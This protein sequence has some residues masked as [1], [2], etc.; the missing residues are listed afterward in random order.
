MLGCLCRTAVAR[1]GC[2]RG[3]YSLASCLPALTP[4]PVGM[5]RV[6][7]LHN[8]KRSGAR[9]RAAAQA[10]SAPHPAMLLDLD[11]RWPDLT[12]SWLDLAGASSPWLGTERRGQGEG[13]EVRFDARSSSGPRIRR[14][15]PGSVDRRSR[16]VLRVP[17]PGGTHAPP[18]RQDEGFAGLA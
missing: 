8:H 1:R 5:G 9:L 3:H 10:N 13:V 6:P 7:H 15:N 18:P 12:P 11:P 2:C 16:S 17:A 14:P 4:A